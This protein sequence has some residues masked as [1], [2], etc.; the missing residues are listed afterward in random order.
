PFS[1]LFRSPVILYKLF[2]LSAQLEAVLF[3]YD[4]LL[5]R[6]LNSFRMTKMYGGHT[7]LRMV[8]RALK[9]FLGI[10]AHNSRLSEH[11]GFGSKTGHGYIGIQ[12]VNDKVAL[13]QFTHHHSM[14]LL[15]NFKELYFITFAF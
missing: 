9:I 10:G 6:H 7:H 11:S 3:V 15:L 2:C 8:K 13:S 14:R 1:N 12:L 5:Y 4:K